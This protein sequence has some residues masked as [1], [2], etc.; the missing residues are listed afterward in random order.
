MDEAES[1]VDGVQL[2][3]TQLI[4]TRYHEEQIWSDKIRRSSTWGTWVLMGL[5]VLLF[6]V[7]TF[8]VE[9][10]K[11]SKLVSAFEDKVKQVLVGISQ[12]NEQ[13]LDPII[14]KLE[15][16]DGQVPIKTSFDFKF[17]TNT[18]HGLKAALVRNYEALMSPEITNL[19][20]DKFEFEL[21]T[22]TVAI[23]AFSMGSLIVS[24]FN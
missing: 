18:W 6:V 7:A 22:M 12:E 13:I 5:N 23:V 9:P 10:W 19:E 2:K 24:L 8:I 20:F 3:L 17:V 1:K 14:E 16:T 11:R 21:F 15:P 4:L